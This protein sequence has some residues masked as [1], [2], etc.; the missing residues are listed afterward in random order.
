MKKIL[1]LII[2]LILLASLSALASE[3]LPSGEKGKET[4]YEEVKSGEKQAQETEEEHEKI[5]LILLLQWIGIF[6]ILGIAGQFTYKWIKRVHTR[7][8][9]LRAYLLTILVVLVLSLNYHPDIKNFHESPSIGFVK[10]LLLLAS[11]TLLT[12]Y[13]VLGRHDEHEEDA[14]GGEE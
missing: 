1:V 12:L 3:K 6:M 2:L 8:E 11:G 13:G 14:H 4:T 10:F 9:A 7:K 5:P